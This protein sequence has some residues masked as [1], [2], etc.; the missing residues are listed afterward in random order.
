MPQLSVIVPIY[1][2]EKFLMRCV[3]SILDQ[4]FRDFEL[5]LI[6]DGSSDASPEICDKIMKNDNR[7]VVIHQDNA[8]VAAARNIGIER[9]TGNYIAFVDSDD[10]IEEEM[11][12]SMINIAEKYNCDVVMCD[13]IKEYKSESKLY[14]HNIRPGYYNKKQLESE[15]FQHLLIMPNIEYPATISNWLFIFKSYLC[16]DCG[17]R[18]EEGIRYSE[19]LL[20]GARMMY[21]AKS[22]Y[23]MKGQTY[24]HYN[25]INS[26]SATH[27]FVADKWRDYQRIYKKTIE[28]F[29]NCSDYNFIEQ[30]DKMLLFFLFNAVNEL[31]TTRTLGIEE[32]AKKILKILSDSVVKEMFHRIEIIKL[33]I[34]SKQKIIAFFYKYR[35]GVKLLCIRSERRG[36]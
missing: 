7:I 18:Y 26:S 31:I 27:T 8:G 30:I 23:Y 35:I 13:C 4:K 3:N 16:K 1:N 20:F 29:G 2:A 22:F 21:L 33:P 34:S 24:Y 25:C 12:F 5:I 11:Y 17:L 10:F 36:K 32:K 28:Y 15:Y 9:A 14:T 19:D 6:D